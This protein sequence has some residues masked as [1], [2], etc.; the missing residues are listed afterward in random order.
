MF[1]HAARF[2]A[3][4]LLL[5]CIARFAL[6]FAIAYEWIG[7]YEQALARYAP[8]ASSSGELIDA[9]N[10]QLPI[11]LGLGALA[12]IAL[13]LRRREKKSAAPSA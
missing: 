9:A 12:E 7:P 8:F 6:G 5:D 10:R 3:I 11:A 1:A 4:L 2:Y 13:T